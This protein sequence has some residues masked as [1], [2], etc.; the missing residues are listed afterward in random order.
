MPIDL[1]SGMTPE[2]KKKWEASYVAPP[3]FEKTP[4]DFAPGAEP[5][6][7][8]YVSPALPAE[9]AA[10]GL[11]GGSDNRKPGREPVKVTTGHA[12][13]AAE[14]E[15]RKA[16]A[17]YHTPAE[18][19]PAAP[20]TR[21]FARPQQGGGGVI[22]GGWQGSERSTTTKKGY[23]VAEPAK[24][25]AVQAVS[26]EQAAAAA[27]QDAGIAKANAESAYFDRHAALQA[28]HV[29]EAV[30]RQDEHAQRFDQEFGKLTQIRDDV[31]NGK[32]D[33]NQYMNS[34]EGLPALAIGLSV[35][36]GAVSQS[37]GGGENPGLK[38]VND[39]IGRNIDA[40]KAN[41]AEKRGKIGD[42]RNLLGDMR[43]QFGDSDKAE[44]ATWLLYLD[45]AKSELASEMAKAT[46]PEVKAKYAGA[47]AE[48]DK[49]SA[50]R[51]ERWS[52][53]A[54]DSIVTEQHERYRPA[55]AAGGGVNEHEIIVEGNKRFN[56][57]NFMPGTSGLAREQA[58]Y[59]S[60]R[61]SFTGRD[62]A[63]GAGQSGV[64]TPDKG[65]SSVI[66]D[67]KPRKAI[68]KNAADAAQ[69]FV[70]SEPDVNQA[71]T[72]LVNA[73]K[74]G[75]VG[76]YNAARGQLLDSMP[77]FMLGSKASGPTRAQARDTY[78]ELIPEYAHWYKKPGLQHRADE[79]LGVLDDMIKG[80]KDT[81]ERSAFPDAKPKTPGLVRPV[82]E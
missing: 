77:K 71:H 30:R 34:K 8:P 44:Q 62:I 17:T 25:A 75:D 61:L 69:D 29:K 3:V 40:Q 33:P 14:L 11:Y 54:N 24:E 81:V 32:I 12:P 79:A 7:P 35:M 72:K 46:I 67:G 80:R 73:W 42:Q 70:E 27:G 65:E 52:K 18:G 28:D 59:R 22:P 36:L 9:Q 31:S 16:E 26:S 68:N 76:A 74:N 41:L 56:D 49:S 2:E 15:K 64:S 20:G 21:D 19:G 38:M 43:A 53:D 5:E 13:D 78:G 1:A 10:I 47:I 66:W 4:G 57:P 23:E 39:A 55:Q 6:A 50:A 48:I 51:Q 82:D 58:A 37:L 63:P 60:A 45:K